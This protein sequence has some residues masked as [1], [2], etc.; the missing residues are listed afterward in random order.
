MYPSTLKF[1]PVAAAALAITACNGSSSPTE[2]SP[3]FAIDGYI[4]GADV[5]C[6]DSANGIT[7]AAG[8]FSCDAGTQISKISSGYDVGFDD[9]ATTGTTPFTGV[10]SAPA[11]ATYV[12]PMSTLS[13]EIALADT[14]LEDFTLENYEAA[15]T[16]LAD[17][18]G[19]EVESLSANP[20]DDLVVAQT[21]S[22]I[23][24]I[25]IAFAPSVSAYEEAVA[26]FATVISEAG[27]SSNVISLTTSVDETVAAINS[28]L[29]LSQ[30]NL[31]KSVTELSQAQ[32]NVSSANEA[33][34]EA[35]SHTAVAEKAQEA[36]LASA[37]VTVN[38]A[39]ATVSLY[40]NS[41]CTVEGSGD[42]MTTL[43]IVD[44]ENPLQANG[45]YDA[46]LT[47]S[48]KCVS[49]DTDV[50][51]FNQSINDA[52]VTVAF[53]VKSVNTNDDWSV[54]I[55]SDDVIVTATRGDSDSLAVSFLSNNA[56]FDIS[57]TDTD[58]VVTRA[59]IETDG[60]T[61][62]SDRDALYLDLDRVNQKL[63]D[64]GFAD[65]LS[66]DGD[67]IVTLVIEG[68]LVN[69]QDGTTITSAQ[70]YT[71]TVDNETV[72]GSGFQGYVSVN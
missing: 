41:S 70:E 67:Y 72:T 44:F 40:S 28:N 62:R 29:E 9:T 32:A 52:Q 50:F 22:M 20:A 64:V 12:T 7:A 54:S 25:L 47:S 1:L 31:A 16:T 60:E 59:A 15:Q 4:V 11:S 14:S 51:E 43:D 8:E 58:G 2:A 26:A 13:L 3:S 35:V 37:P 45:R 55:F 56:S 27:A 33:I 21:N 23:H 46:Q 69:E 30:S 42:S 18:L 36:V 53:E 17:T 24:Q 10:L 6:D 66:R 68:P 48:M 49:Y 38:R 39:D 57:A 19:I 63:S 61:F 34:S 71:V 65:V 5:F